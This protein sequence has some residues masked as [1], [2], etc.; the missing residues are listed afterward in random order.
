MIKGHPIQNLNSKREIPRQARAPLLDA[1]AI[2]TGVGM[3][4]VAFDLQRRGRQLRLFFS[5][6]W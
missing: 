4:M 1:I 6:G 5:L 3:R 2:W